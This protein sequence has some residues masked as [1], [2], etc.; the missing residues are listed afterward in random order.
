MPRKIIIPATILV[1][2]LTGVATYALLAGR[3][4]TP[5]VPSPSPSA[6]ASVSPSASPKTTSCPTH[7]D[8]WTVGSRDGGNLLVSG[9]VTA[10][11]TGQ[12]DCYD[13]IVFDVAT[14]QKVG[15]K[16]EYVDMV[17]SDGAGKPVK[18]AG[19]ASLRLVIDAWAE[20]PALKGFGPVSDWKAL[21]EIKN[22]GSFE[23]VT[24]Y[25]IG[26]AHRTPFHVDRLP[27]PDGKSQRIVVDIVHG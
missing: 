2:L 9:K 23:G 19:K 13:R 4:T 17:T 26:V 3:V 11:R 22:A 1:I 8:D 6:S 18:V 10:V 16:A 5:S 15:Y 24:T 21:T 14:T 25:A 20:D 27:S 12:H 7:V